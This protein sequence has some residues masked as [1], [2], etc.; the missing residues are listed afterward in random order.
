MELQMSVER[1]RAEHGVEIKH[2][3][4][5]MDKMAADIADIRKSLYEINKT[6]SEAKGGWKTMMMVAGFASAV[7]GTLGFLIHYFSGK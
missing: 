6:L 7:S 2:I 4:D 3:Q 5:D 1:E